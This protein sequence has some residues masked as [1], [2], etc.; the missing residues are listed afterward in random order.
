MPSEPDDWLARRPR[1]WWWGW[2]SVFGLTG[3]A[4]SL[5][6]LR[7]LGPSP[8]F[9]LAHR[10][11]AGGVVAFAFGIA[12]VVPGV[13]ASIATVTAAAGWSQART[14]LIGTVG[15]I[16]GAG[17]LQPLAGLTLFPVLAL[18]LGVVI[19]VAESR[20]NP[21]M[22][23]ALAGCAVVPVILVG[24]FIGLSRTSSYVFVQDV[25]L[26]DLAPQREALPPVMF[27]VFDEL[28][29]PALL[30]SDLTINE[31]RF[32]NFARLADQSDWYRL[33][34][35]VSPQTEFSV[36][37]LLSGTSPTRD[38]AVASNYPSSIFLQLGAAYDVFAFESITGL[39]PDA[40]C[41]PPTQRPMGEAD[42]AAEDGGV[43]RLLRDSL[44]V[45][46]HA[47]GSDA[48]RDGLPAIDHSWSGFG[49]P[50][51]MLDPASMDD[52]ER[53]EYVELG[54]AATHH[55][56]A[57]R[58]ME[59]V[60][61]R[62][63]GNRPPL[64]VAHLITPH[65]PYL[66]NPSGSSHEH[67]PLVGMETSDHTLHWPPGGPE[68]SRRQGYQRLLL[69]LGAVD[70]LLGQVMDELQSAGL[71]EDAAV[72]VTADHGASFEEGYFR[73]VTAADAEVWN[74]PLFI[75]APGQTEGRV[76]DDAALTID[77]V[78]TLLDAIGI[79]SASDFGGVDLDSDTVPDTR[80]DAFADVGGRTTV[81]QSL[82]A[83][84]EL[85]ARRARWVDPDGGWERAYRVGPG[86]E[87]VGTAVPAA[88]SNGGGRWRPESAGGSVPAVRALT[89]E[90][91]G[92]EL[93]AGVV[94]AANGRFVGVGS[95]VVETD[96]HARVVVVMDEASAR[97]DPST[98]ELF[99]VDADGR[100]SRLVADWGE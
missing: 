63:T 83:V 62:P 4:L 14:L 47:I 16:A 64:Y 42:R 13:V 52:P 71:W 6:V 60:Q 59:L 12:V 100:L 22:V 74:V 95:P 51:T 53:N 86:A 50:T 55:G 31:E 17:V 44:V 39:C 10:I 77:A 81:D 38:V 88:V 66:A 48:M 91:D 67:L 7:V 9:F 36:P 35:S 2:L 80:R 23:K 96:G 29:A 97:A 11:D 43:D 98:Y 85:I 68:A 3:F 37:A 72:V 26:A 58:M 34:S 54:D 41:R 1:Q 18:A 27:I 32:P 70:T 56:A 45:L 93:P 19:A 78:P 87:L 5:P 94:L 28:P 65:L 73:D 61:R 20:R 24:W 92:D 25:A 79:D 76:R 40:V 46:G 8:E 75:R 84:A 57:A 89:L 49:G 82:E 21:T 69:Q 33:A 15:T 99:T 90:L 30:G